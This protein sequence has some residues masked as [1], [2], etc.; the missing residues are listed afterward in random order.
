MV[1]ALASAARVEPGTYQPM[2]REYV[3]ALRAYRTQR[4]GTTGMDVLPA[5]KPPDRYYDDNAWMALA[6]AET[7]QVTRE[8]RD[9]EFADESLRFALS[10]ED[11]KLGGGI[12]WH[13]DRYEKKHAV[14]SAPAA[15]TALELYRVT[16]KSEYL[17]IGKR[18]YDWTAAH[19][20]GA[21][22]LYAD[23][24]AVADGKVDQSK[25]AYNSGMMIRAACLLHAITHDAHYMFD[26][27]KTA[28][29]AEKRWVRPA[30][31]AIQDEAPLAYKLC[32]A[33]LFV[34]VED[35]DAHWLNVCGRA[36]GYVHERCRDPN[37]W[38]A[39]RW[40]A[41]DVAALDPI[42]LIHQ[43][44]AAR[45]YWMAAAHGVPVPQP[46]TAHRHGAAGPALR[47]EQG[48]QPTPYA[49]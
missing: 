29:A 45:A 18:L 8:Q 17:D 13:E 38:Y 4:N 27:H 21:D 37:G 5:P 44:S 30:D 7:Y 3:D 46:L 1:S 12:Y 16:G 40:D 19:L 22:G 47:I 20:Q 23:S 42:Q 28:R 10:G 39:K 36:I 15:C 49:Y 26:A 9:L 33:F 11:D 43:A 34:Y 35:H 6:L 41:H 2:L 14:S 48:R 32:E 24:T 31:G 25:Y